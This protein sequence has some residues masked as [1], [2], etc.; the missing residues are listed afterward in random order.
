[1]ARAHALRQ[2]EFRLRAGDCDDLLGAGEDRQARMQEAGR[3]LSQHDHGIVGGDAGA[4]LRVP[5]R[6][7]RLDEGCF[8]QRKPGRQR[9]NIPRAQ[10]N[11]LAE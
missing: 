6:R 1:M 4:Y 2:I 10:A 3:A 7:Q 11:I 5:H 9:V 8:S